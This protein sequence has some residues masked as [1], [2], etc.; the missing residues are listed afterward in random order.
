MCTHRWTNLREYTG[1]DRG[2]SL[3]GGNIQLSN[4]CTP[5]TKVLP[6]IFLGKWPTIPLQCV[7]ATNFVDSPP[8]RDF[9][10]KFAKK[11]SF[12]VLFFG[13]FNIFSFIFHNFSDEINKIKLA[14]SN[15]D[16]LLVCILINYVRNHNERKRASRLQCIIC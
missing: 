10:K 4:L 5:V 3:G 2:I 12:S 1:A 8:F 16:F 14:L 7:Y 6:T 11:K 13:K 15:L 9:E